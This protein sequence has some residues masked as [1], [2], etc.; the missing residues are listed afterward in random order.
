MTARLA[1]LVVL[2]LLAVGASRGAAA[3]A[4][5][6]REFRAAT[7]LAR[8]GDMQ[9]DW[10]KLLDARTRLE[11]L[12]SNPAISARVHFELGYLEWR[13]SALAYMSTGFRGQVP[14]W[15]RAVSELERAVAL[16]PDLAD[17][18]GLIA[19]C[20]TLLLAADP[21]Q[22][23][24]LKPRIDAA[25]KNALE[26][27][28]PSPR[29]Q[30]FRAMTVFSAPPAQGGNQ[31]TG[32]ELWREAIAGLESE[33]PTDPLAP[34]WGLAEAWGWLGGA[35]LMQGDTGSAKS[36]FTRALALRKDFWWVARVAL[37]QA[38][39][40]AAPAA[41]ATSADRLSAA[42]S[43]FGLSSAVVD[44]AMAIAAAIERTLEAFALMGQSG[45]S[46]T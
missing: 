2:M 44:W 29:A 8:D 18:H 16:Q 10:N 36:A 1:G 38:E 26:T 14:H 24:R 23:D 33:K 46:A 40:P 32:I 31:A 27:M 41:A 5:D 42:L 4:P 19:L 21:S 25:W 30:L 6:A 15:R 20:S 35:Y 43:R 3:Y 45:P 13:L 7:R 11:R 37:P 39:R 22:S 17:A 28:R 34:E 12:T 9:A